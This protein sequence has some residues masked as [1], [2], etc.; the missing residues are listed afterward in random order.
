M[1]QKIL[2]MRTASI[3][4]LVLFFSK[5]NFS[6]DSLLSILE[7]SSRSMTSTYPVQATFKALHIVN[8]HTIESPA[9][10]DLNFIIMHRFGRV[11]EGAYELFGLDNA[12]IRLGLDYG[13]T[14]RLGIGIGRSSI[15]KTFDGY[16]K[17]KLIRQADGNTKFP[18]SMSILGSIAN[19]TKKF[20][21]KSYL[22]AKYRTTYITQI[23][24][25][26]KFSPD[27][28]LQLTPSWL[29]FNL[30]PSVNDNNNVFASTIGGRLK[31]TKRMG[32]TA[33]YSYLFPDQI[34]SIDLPNSLSLGWDIETGGHV[35]QLV[36]S[37]SRGMIEPQYIANVADVTAV[38]GKWTKGDIYFGFN[39]SRN[40]TLSKKNK[41]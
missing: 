26:R 4:L 30:V 1:D 11:N 32:I 6:Q 12:Y 40:F 31:F 25:A 37:N 18:V 29:H 28:S 8:I 41:K 35:F 20:Q 14:D 9:K 39:L 22:N 15:D 13:I 23:F 36:F 21:T 7:D 27:F 38:N 16:V 17:Y 34:R 2:S 5:T 33:E 3:L 19:Y 24:I 10:R